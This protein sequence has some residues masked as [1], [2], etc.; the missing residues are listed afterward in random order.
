MCLPVLQDLLLEDRALIVLY[1]QCWCAGSWFTDV[2]L[3]WTTM[4]TALADGDPF[5]GDVEHHQILADL[6]LPVPMAGDAVI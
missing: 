2:G 5:L 1:I 4:D 3:P 6:I